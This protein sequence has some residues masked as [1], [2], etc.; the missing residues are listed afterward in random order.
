MIYGVFTK[1]RHAEK[2]VNYLNDI[3]I[4]YSISTCKYGPY[5]V[6]YD[7][8]VCYGYP[9]LIAEELLDKPWYN[10]H[11]APLPEY[12]DWGNYIRGLHDLQTGKITRWGVSLHCIDKGV[13]SGEV[14]KM[15]SIPLMS[16]PCCKSELGDISHYYLFQLF[17]QT[18]HA[19]KEKPR[20]WEELIQFVKPYRWFDALDDI[21]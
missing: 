12:K 17:K 14:L 3:D 18:V 6:E 5:E 2:L 11:P 13:D 20:N 21:C 4:E 19:L 7:I 16:I 15:L 10:Y 8:G 9:F 1:K